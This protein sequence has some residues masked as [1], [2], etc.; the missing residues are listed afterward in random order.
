METTNE[1][2]ALTMAARYRQMAE[3]LEKHPDLPI[4]VRTV[5]IDVFIDEDTGDSKQQLIKIAR[6]LGHSK[7]DQFGSWYVLTAPVADGVQ[8]DFN[9][10]REKVCTKVV[11]GQRERIVPAQEA[12]KE[13]T[14]MEPIYEWQCDE[15]LLK[16]SK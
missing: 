15:S 14:I 3:Y 10:N 2:T 9:A 16:G 7:K 8:I 11:V 4:P 5:T 12:V 13:H 1:T 6:M